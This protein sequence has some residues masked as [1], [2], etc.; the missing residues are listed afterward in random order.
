VQV[1]HWGRNPAHSSLYIYVNIVEYNIER[2]SIG[3]DKNWEDVF[4]SVLRNLVRIGCK[5]ISLYMVPL[6]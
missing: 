4:L 2:W 1:V 6:K 5:F 3:I